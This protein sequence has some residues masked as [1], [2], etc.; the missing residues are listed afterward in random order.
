MD[1]HG[2]SRKPPFSPI[3]ARLPRNLGYLGSAW[4]MFDRFFGAALGRKAGTGHRKYLLE[5]WL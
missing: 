1:V 2:W 5:G 3:D 4:N